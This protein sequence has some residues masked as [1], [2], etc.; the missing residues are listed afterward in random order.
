MF[1]FGTSGIRDLTK[2]LL[3]DQV[4]TEL[5][6]KLYQMGWRELSLGRD[7]RKGSDKLQS[8][9]TKNFPGKIYNCGITT[10][11]MLSAQS[12]LAVMITASHNPSEYCGFKVFLNHQ[13]QS[14]AEITPAPVYQKWQLLPKDIVID[15]ANGG[16]GHQ[17]KI[18]GFTNLINDK[19]LINHHCGANHTESLLRHCQEN[20]LDIGFAVDGDADRFAMYLGNRILTSDEVTYLII[21]LR[22]FSTIVVDETVNSAL[23]EHC[24]IIRSQVGGHAVIAAMQAN[25]V[26]FGA[27]NSGHYYFDRNVG[28]SDAVD[29][30]ILFSNA[31]HTMGT[32]GLLK[33]LKQYHPYSQLH[34]SI[35]TAQL[36]ANYNE[37]LSQLVL[38]KG[39][40]RIIRPSGTEPLLR[41]MLES[42]KPHLIDKAWSIVIDALQ[43]K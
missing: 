15:C 42:K 2:N 20:H 18:L 1:K 4:A 10:T 5:A 24:Q 9:F 21:K 28:T 3:K 39:V 43:T 16:L 37:I 25:S 27:E 14:T 13:E 33:L 36:P 35:P 40:R 26:E 34:Q 7:G 29:A 32:V 11:P 30:M 38:P 22:R 8:E 6:Q 41:V 19:G 12:G 17:L 31:Y 23:A